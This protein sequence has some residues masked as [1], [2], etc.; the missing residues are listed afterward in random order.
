MEAVAVAVSEPWRTK[1]IKHT[2]TTMMTITPYTGIGTLR[3]P[4]GSAFNEYLLS[5]LT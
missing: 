1:T 3:P 2:K 4:R 5:R